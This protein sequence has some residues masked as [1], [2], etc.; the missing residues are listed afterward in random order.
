MTD[1]EAVPDPVIPADAGADEL[2]DLADHY[3]LLD[4]LAAVAAVEDAFDDRYAGA[5]LTL[6]QRGRRA[7]VRGLQAANAEDEDAVAEIAWTSALDLFAAAGDEIRH[8]STRAR[9]GLLMC[10][11]DRANFGLGIAQDATDYLLA[12]AP[13]AKHCGAHRRLAFAYL[14]SGRPDDALASLDLAAATTATSDDPHAEVRIPVERAGILAQIGRLDEA[15]TVAET[16]VDACRRADYR[17]GTAA[18]CWILGRVAQNR[19]DLDSALA[20]YDEA[21]AAA[22]RPLF[23]RE[24]RRQRAIMLASTSHAARVID[25]LLDEVAT[26]AESGDAEAGR[27]ARFHLAGAYL[28]TGRA[29]EAAE[30]LQEILRSMEPDEAAAESV[31]HMLASAFRVL[32]EPDAAIEQ[33]TLIAASGARR[34]SPALIGEMH[35]QI[36][37]ILDRLDRDSLAATHFAASAQAYREAG[38]VLEAVRSGRRAATSHMWARQMDSAVE[39]LDAVD[40][41]ALDLDPER[42][43]ARWERGMLFVDG[44]RIL[45][46]H[47]DL[48]TAIIRCAPAIGLLVAV[49]DRESAAF[50][51]V[52]YGEFLVR[53]DRPAEAEP[54]LRA[55]FTESGSNGNVRLRAAQALAYALGVLGRD[56]EAAEFRAVSENDE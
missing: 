5:E 47:G 12:H 13:V 24:I 11:T 34:D 6:L 28:N 8:Q 21:L 56:E 1:D 48:S 7:D 43:E 35:E 52:T 27:I 53:A 32:D 54:A 37:E 20:A 38:L 17:A 22:D 3:L 18:A 16:A 9:L 55:A 31:R 10:K 19:R 45:A 39:A 30:L 50:A 42:T 25:D 49:G 33:L 15:A 46:Q 23:K 29:G 2:L 44:A 36:A 51:Q 14:L 40:R 4:D 26:A 41:V